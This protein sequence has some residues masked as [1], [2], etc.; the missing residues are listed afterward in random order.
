MYICLCR[1]ERAATQ[2]REVCTAKYCN[3][4]KEL[5]G[6]IEGY[7]Q[8]K[9]ILEDE[10]TVLRKELEVCLYMRVYICMYVCIHN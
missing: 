3:Q 9:S 10:C 7:I 5:K 4:V 2:E 1:C 8:S 6:R